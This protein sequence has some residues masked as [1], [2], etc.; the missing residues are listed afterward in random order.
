MSEG[1]QRDRCTHQL[2]ALLRRSHREL[3]M[4]CR[5]HP[6]SRWPARA[7]LASRLACPVHNR[8]NI[9]SWNGDDGPSTT[10]LYLID[11]EFAV[12]FLD[13]LIGNLHGA[14]SGHGVP[15]I[16]RGNS[17]R[18]HVKGLLCKLG[19][20]RF[21]HPLLLQGSKRSLLDGILNPTVSRV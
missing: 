1:G 14:E 4:I 6:V 11:V 16:V 7:C 21:V 20:L 2:R 12:L 15:Q 9:A 5:V 17:G 3:H 13:L 8:H 18:F 10:Y 19:N